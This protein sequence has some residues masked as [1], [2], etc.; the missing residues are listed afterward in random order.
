MK[1]LFKSASKIVFILLAIA[2]VVLTFV[3]KVDSKDFIMLT[4]GVFS[5]YFGRK[6]APVDNQPSQE[7]NLG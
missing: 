2:L 7:S 5:Y 4:T 1:E 3:G 6:E